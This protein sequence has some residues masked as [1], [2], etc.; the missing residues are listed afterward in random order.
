MLEQ[1]L[2]IKTPSPEQSLQF[3][4][5]N[6]NQCEVWVKRDDLLHPVISGN[7]W[8]KLKYALQ[9][10]YAGQSS[11]IISFGGGYSNHLHALG[12]CCNQLDIAFTAIVRGDYSANMT[13]TLT[14]LSDWGAKIK[15]VDKQTYQRRSDH[16]YL[17][18]LQQQ[19]P[20]AVVIPE[21][22]SQRPALSGVADMVNELQHH[23]DYILLPVASGGTLAGLIHSQINTKLIGIAV[24]KGQ[25]YLEQ[26]VKDLLSEHSPTQWQIAHHFHH[27]GYAKQPDEL[28]HFCQQSQNDLNIPLEPVYSGKLFYAAR[29][30][31][32]EQYFPQGSRIL[33]LHT[34]GL[35]AG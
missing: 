32:A 26:L 10:I 15:F 9:A 28:V 23:Y 12:Y 22:G 13:P 1:I 31:L 29:E 19:Y 5:P 33:L 20:E 2:Q 8:R 24:L 14:A 3:D 17:L 34:G 4:W 30:L 18:E 11:Q 25:G 35:Q 6:P 7:K 16:D 21:G 27:G